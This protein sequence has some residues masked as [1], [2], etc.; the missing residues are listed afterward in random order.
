ASTDHIELPNLDGI[1]VNIRFDGSDADFEADATALMSQLKTQNRL[2][3]GNSLVSSIQAQAHVQAELFKL[4]EQERTSICA[5]NHCKSL[6]LQQLAAPQGVRGTVSGLAEGKEVRLQLSMPS[7]TQV[8]SVGVNGTFGFVAKPSVGQTYTVARIDTDPSVS[9]TVANASGVMPALGVSNVNVVCAEVPAHTGTLG[10]SVSG[11]SAGQS[12]T[13]E[14]LYQN[15]GAVG[16]QSLTVSSNGTY[17]FANPLPGGSLYVAGVTSTVPSSLS[18]TLVSGGGF[19][20]TPL[21]YTT[22]FAI[23]DL[24]VSCGSPAPQYYT[25]GGTVSG[26]PA[27]TPIDLVMAS[28]DFASNQMAAGITNGGYQFL[29]TVLGGSTISIATGP[30]P[31]GV[32]CTV[33]PTYA[34]GAVG[35]VINSTVTNA[36]VTCSGGTGPL[37]VTVAVTGLDSGE[38]VTL[39]MLA[40]SPSINETLAFA[41][42]G[43]SQFATLVP[44]GTAVTVNLTGSP[45]GKTCQ[46]FAPQAILAG[47]SAVAVNCT[48]SGGGGGGGLPLVP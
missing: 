10:G 9:C 41:T 35:T 36:N 14:V 30:L 17:T 31:P 44:N 38:S 24:N 43:P 29:T 40:V 42:T 13:L 7:G 5:V 16:T 19:N 48:T 32:T 25:V 11:L 46:V 21:R 8:L 26:L 12:V 47:N 22:S 37:T 33:T 6:L 20:Q 4:T 18:C 45:A 15:A 1:T 3:A 27:M 2:P 28:G 34:T 23:N 39:Q